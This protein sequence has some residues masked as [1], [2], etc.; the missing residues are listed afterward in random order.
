MQINWFIVIAQIINFF[1]LVWLLK[2]FLYKPILRAIDEREKKIVS[3]LEEAESKKNEAIREQADFQKKNEEFDCQRQ[4]LMDQVVAEINK[5]RQRLLE[6]TRSEADLLRDNLKKSWFESRE[7]MKREIRQKMQEEIFAIVRM[8]LSDL[9]SR[10]LE[11]Q[12]VNVFI[13]RLSELSEEEK[14]QFIHAFQSG[15]SPVLIQCAFPLPEQQQ[16]ELVR[17]VSDILGGQPQYQ[18]RTAPGIVSGI[19]LTLNGYKLAWSIAEYLRSFENS[20]SE[21]LKIKSETASD[22]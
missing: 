2:R 3:Q 4:M 6:E 18:F 17:V 1:I 20:I 12:S 15:L 21:T 13:R 10:S 22:N 11:E 19:E 9:A 16:E 8:T 5:E 7:I 14:G